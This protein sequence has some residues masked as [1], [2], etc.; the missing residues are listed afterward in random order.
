MAI[1]LPS[2]IAAVSE[3]ILIQDVIDGFG[4]YAPF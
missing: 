4:F 2:T 1:A 3:L